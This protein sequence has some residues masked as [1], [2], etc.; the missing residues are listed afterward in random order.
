MKK[1][2]LLTIKFECRINDEVTG[3]G[4]IESLD[5]TRRVLEAISKDDRALLEL[6]TFFLYQ[7][8]MEPL[9]DRD[10]FS[11][12]LSIKDINDIFLGLTKKLPPETAAYIEHLYAEDSEP[13]DRRDFAN[14]DKK[15]ELLENQFGPLEVKEMGFKEI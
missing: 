5:H 6:F 11:R 9:D 10:I 4:E 15:K 1:T 12:G 14:W 7:R 3:I 8:F 2:Y 13:G